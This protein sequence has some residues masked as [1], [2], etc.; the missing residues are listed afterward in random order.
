MPPKLLELSTPTYRNQKTL[1]WLQ[2]QPS[3]MWSRWDGIVSSIA[4]YKRWYDTDARLVGM[5]L[6]K[7][8]G[9]QDTFL[10]DLY[11]IAKDIPMVLVSRAILS[12]KSEDFWA[13]NFDNLMCLNDILDSY[14]FLQTPWNQTVEDAIAIFAIMF[15]YHRLVDVVQSRMKYVKDIVPQEAWLFTQYFVH[16]NKKRAKEI[17]ECL[18]KNCAC[19]E[20]SRI[21]LF[22]EMDLSGEWATIPGSEKIQQVVTGSRLTYDVFLNY[23]S[24]NVP[25][26]VFAILANADIYMDSSLV[27][28][29]KIDMTD[30][31]LALLRWD[32]RSGESAL[33]GPRPDSQDSWIMLSDS[34]R[35]VWDPVVF[36]FPLGKLGCDNAFAAHMLRNRFVL[37]NPALTIQTHHLHESGIRNYSIKDVISSDIY[38]H[39]TPTYLLDTVQEQVPII[40]PQF[41][42]NELA[43]F[44]VR[45]TS[46]SNEITYCTMLEK[47][48]R[49]S[50]TPSIE[51][52]YFVPAIPIY[53]WKKAGVTPNGMVYDLHTVYVGKHAKEEQYQFWTGAHIDILTPLQSCKRM[54]AIPFANTDVFHHPD[55]YVLQY[56]S[57]VLRILREYPCTSCWLPAGFGSYL[58][59]FNGLPSFVEWKEDTGCWADEVVGFLP[60]PTCSE[61]GREDINGLRSLLPSWKPNAS[62]NRC[63]VITDSTITPRFIYERLTPWL[64]KDD[65]RWDISVV[66]DKNPGAYDS[67]VGASLCILVGGHYNKWS[68]LWAL[69]RNCWVV[70][71][72]QE[73]SLDGEFQHLCHVADVK[74]WILLLAKGSVSDVQDQIM[75]QLEK[76]HKEKNRS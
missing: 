72:Q 3:M 16:P 33:F 22:N 31:M 73:L 75:E 46:S 55:T 58:S 37:S 59:S 50:W 27:N 57:R 53:S 64:K 2:H 8:E 40:S 51:N 5:V 26:N 4:D 30:R 29:W 7:V 13:E 62:S 20:I 10:E 66:S 14:P 11:S 15:R 36:G 42:C 67:I 69:P 54:A 23:V 17:R 47:A 63:V 34:I 35:R 6:L 52:S 32:V 41:I 76:W 1:I 24:Q 43:V 25:A 9:D 21:V 45:S 74:S 48:G 28:L 38:L 60:G 68:K 39:L 56:L 49:Y 70:E 65:P 61:L 18:V 19:S 12:L 71:F 44:E